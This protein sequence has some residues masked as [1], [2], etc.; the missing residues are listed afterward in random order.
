M[1]TATAID[2]ASPYIV[3]SW[4]QALRVLQGMT[5]HE[6]LAH[7][8]M[9]HWGRRTRCGTV[10]CIGGHCVLDPWFQE[11]RHLYP[12][13]YNECLDVSGPDFDRVFGRAW[14]YIFT[15]MSLTHEDAVRKVQRHIAILTG[16]PICPLGF[17]MPGLTA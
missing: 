13:W 14:K 11:N 3:E 2:E 4:R 5:T 15:C 10:A 7:F 12:I 1:E 17:G 9:H 8:K 6:R 16:E